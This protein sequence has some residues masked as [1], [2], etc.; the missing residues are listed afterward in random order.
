LT[1]NR[2]NGLRI[3]PTKEHVERLKHEL[4]RRLLKVE[5]VNGVGIQRAE[6]PEEYAL[7]VHV[8]NDTP[9]TRAAVERETRGEPVRIVQSGRLK[10]L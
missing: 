3:M 8:E 6:D 2:R 4:S 9:D 1:D 10:K 7:V 5:G